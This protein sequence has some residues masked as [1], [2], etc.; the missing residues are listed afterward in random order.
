MYFSLFLSILSSIVFFVTLLLS[1][2][3]FFLLLFSRKSLFLKDR[4]RLLY[5]SQ[6]ELLSYLSS[7]LA[8]IGTVFITNPLP[9]F[10]RASP[11]TS[12]DKNFHKIILN[13][14]HSKF[15]SNKSQG[16]PIRIYR[17]SKNP[18][19]TPIVSGACSLAHTYGNSVLP[20]NI[21]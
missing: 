19:N 18:F 3:F 2:P 20:S 13:Y 15:I 6:N 11:S 4:K 10:H 14:I 7:Y 17:I 5:T 8:G 9:R 16:I 21:I 1:L 12:R